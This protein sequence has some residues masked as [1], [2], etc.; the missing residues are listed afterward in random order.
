M[1]LLAGLGACGGDGDGAG[2]AGA[3]GAAFPAA[4]ARLAVATYKALAREVYGATASEA[5]GLQGAIDAFVAAPDEAGHK[6][7]KEAWLR[8]RV[9]YNQN[10]A[11]RFYNG[12][13][14]RDPGGPE[15]DING[16]PLDE[17]FVDYT[18]DEAQAGI[19][20]QPDKVATIDQ[21]VI[22]KK[23]GEGGEKNLSVG[24][25]AI[26]FLLWGQDDLVPGQGAG[27]RP[28]TDFV[29]GG[30]AGNQARRRD[31]LKAAAGLLVGQ[32]SGVEQAWA[33]GADNYAAGFGVKPDEGSATGDGLKDAIGNMIRG[34]GS[35]AKAELSGERMTVA[36]KSRAQ[37]DEHSC[38][39]DSTWNDLF[40]NALGIQ[41]VWLGQFKGQ[42]LGPGLDSVFRAV[43][44]A[45]A[46]Q[47]GKDIDEA[48]GK[49]KGLADAND[50]APFDV[51]IAEPDG[52]A[53]RAAA[54]D[55]VKALKR[56]ADGLASGAARM[57]LS[58][59]LEKASE[60][61]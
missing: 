6:A 31:Y 38:F 40:G 23:N 24:Y 43:D 46:D 17:N 33:P 42:K 37:E 45:L 32:L 15:G 19:I 51:V 14:D 49:L 55:A 2:G 36:L 59:E 16:W 20:N 52:S 18:R 10:D 27:K 7:A 29:D 22:A 41:N 61:L 53:S 12:P 44:G 34:L 25:H 60:E 30:T 21:G 57:G 5:K 56:A 9:P 50:K 28:Y 13:I 48:V 39:S 3:S 35:L 54:I 58:V 8:A 4:E 11:F 26:E 1:I 47:I